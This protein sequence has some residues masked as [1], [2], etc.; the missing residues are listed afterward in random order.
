M[1]SFRRIHLTTEVILRIVA[2][3]LMVSFGYGAAV[4]TRFVAALESEGEPRPAFWEYV[5]LLERGLCVVLPIAIVN[6][7]LAGLYTRGR[8][9]AAWY[10]A[11]VIGEAVTLTFLIFGFASFLLPP[12]W[13]GLPRSVVFMAWGYTLVIVGM[14]RLWLHV[15]RRVSTSAPPPMKPRNDNRRILVIGGAGYVGSA[16]LPKLLERGFKVRVLDVMLFGK[17]PI[18]EIASH[19]NLEIVPAD[20]RQIDRLV[21]AT[22]DVDSVVHLGGLVGDPSCAFDERL[23]LEINLVATRMIAE[24]AKGSGVSHF[25]FASTCSVYGASDQILTERSR[26]NPVSLYAQSKIASER[27]LQRIQDKSFSV[28]ALRFGTIFG[29]SGRTRFDLVVNLLTAKAVVEGKIT[30]FGGEQWRPFLHVDDAAASVLR[31]LEAPRP[32]VHNEIFNV[33]SNDQNMTLGQLGE[34]IQRAVPGAQLIDSAAD[35]DRRNYR[36]D[37]KKIRD[38]LGFHPKWKVEDGIQ[39]VIAALRSGKITDYKA[40]EYSNLKY[41]AEESSAR[42]VRQY[43]GGW[44]SPLLKQ[45]DAAEV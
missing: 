29:I 30:V 35:G 1:P 5:S 44:E 36:V 19:P 32:L 45:A 23:T 7:A 22:Q 21:E 9:Y 16:L 18:A 14:S 27:V 31:V 15:W 38:V 4:M 28:T 42:G 40:P 8:S 20:F 6:F 11:L 2:D 33:G 43:Y 39:Q 12:Q 13:L 24:V 17:G 10:K 26:L 25:V 37:F 34:A 41:L 3:S